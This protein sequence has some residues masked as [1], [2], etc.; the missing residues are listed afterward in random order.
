MNGR[1][2][3]VEIDGKPALNVYAKWTGKKVKD[4][5]GMNLLSASVTEPLGVKD[6]L[7]SLIAIRHPMIGN[8]DLSMNVGNNL[9]INTAVIQMQA[10]VDELIAGVFRWRAECCLLPIFVMTP[11][12]GI[13]CHLR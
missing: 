6:R 1:R 13:S 8:E 11:S 5:A 10:S 7:G 9:A 3:L 12:V 4:L 2:Q